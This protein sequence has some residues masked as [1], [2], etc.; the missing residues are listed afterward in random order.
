VVVIHGEPHPGNAMLAAGG[1]RLID[2]GDDDQS[3]EI[4]G[5]LR[6]RL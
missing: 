3:W 1:W 5:S 4:L 6:G 2:T